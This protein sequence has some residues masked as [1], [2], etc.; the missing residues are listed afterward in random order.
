MYR[1]PITHRERTAIIF[2]LDC[3]MSMLQPTKIGKLVRPK[4]EIVSLICNLMIDELV[5]RATRGDRVRNY[6]DIAVLGY[7][8]GCVESLLPGE[9]EGFIAVDRLAELMPAPTTVYI[10]QHDRDG[11]IINAPITLH[12][13]IAPRAAGSTPM[14]EALATVHKLVEEWCSNLDNRHSFPPMVFH[15]TDGSCSNTE[16]EALIEIASHIKLTHTED[17]NTLLF[18]IHLSSDIWNNY[19]EI[20]P[21]AKKWVANHPERATLFNMSS[22]IPKPLEPHVAY[23]LGL[24]HRGPYRGVAFNTAPCDLLAIL[25]I[26][27]ESINNVKTR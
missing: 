27:T 13:W 15:I 22:T 19:H 12:E 6:Y 16:R 20:F 14:L 3:S 4:V 1:Q 24:K 18:N 17:G 23:L 10:E 25:N 11:S 7:S 5:V 9:G 2:L 26:G 8:R 21:N